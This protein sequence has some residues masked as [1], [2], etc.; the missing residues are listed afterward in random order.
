LLDELQLSQTCVTVHADDDVVV[1]GGSFGFLS[2]EP[3][4]AG[5]VN[6]PQPEIEHSVSVARQRR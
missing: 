1:D 3:A 2:G 5:G 6:G 4:V